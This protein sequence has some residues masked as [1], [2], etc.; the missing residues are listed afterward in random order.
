MAIVWVPQVCCLCL[1]AFWA[2]LLLVPYSTY[3]GTPGAGPLSWTLG[4]DWD[5]QGETPG[6]IPGWA[7]HLSVCHAMTFNAR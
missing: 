5:P 1:E 7:Y 4:I 3:W 6:W 2:P